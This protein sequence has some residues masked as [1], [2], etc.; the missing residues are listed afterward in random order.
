MPIRNGD[1]SS[2]SSAMIGG[3]PP[4]C[5]PKAASYRCA[6]CGGIILHPIPAFWATL[7]SG[8]CTRSACRLARL[9][10]LSEQGRQPH[11]PQALAFGLRDEVLTDLDAHVEKPSPLSMLWNCPVCRVTDVVGLVIPHRQRTVRQK[12]REQGMC[13]P[14][15]PMMEK[16]YVPWAV[17][18]GKNGREAVHRDE[19]GRS[20]QGMP[21]IKLGRNTRMIG[22]KDF[23]FP[24]LPVCNV[25]GLVAGNGCSVARDRDRLVCAR[26]AVTVDDQPRIVLLNERCIE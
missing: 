4:S 17:Q 10:R 2:G 14:I 24:P 19:D 22:R 12:E 20:P 5:A 9:R 11:R 8:V 6:E 26:R 1:A 13:K 25:E 21:T 3:R 18:A 15:I 23:C 16:S 7:I